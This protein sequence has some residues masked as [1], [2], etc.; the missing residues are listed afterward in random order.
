MVSPGPDYLLLGE[1][2]RVKEAERR[3]RFS[4]WGVSKDK[5]SQAAVPSFPLL[6]NHCRGEERE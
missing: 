1:G 2:H 3:E 5:E 4:K 6:R